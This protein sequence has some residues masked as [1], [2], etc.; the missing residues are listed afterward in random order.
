[1]YTFLAG[2]VHSLLSLKLGSLGR[3]HLTSRPVLGLISRS[4]K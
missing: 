4:A 2:A 1:M 3:M